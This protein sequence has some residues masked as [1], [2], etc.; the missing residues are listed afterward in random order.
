[1]NEL[2]F[3]VKMTKEENF[4]LHNGINKESERNKRK[5]GPGPAG[6][7]PRLRLAVPFVFFR[8][9]IVGLSKILD[10][11]LCGRKPVKGPHGEVDGAAVVDSKLF[12]DV[13]QRVKV[14]AGVK[15]FLVLPVA[16]FRLA[17]VAGCVRPYAF[18]L[19]TEFGKGFLKERRTVRF[20]IVQPVG[21]LN[22]CRSGYTQ[23]HRGIFQQ[24]GEGRGWKNRCCVPQRLRDSGSGNTHQ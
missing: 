1:M 2:E 3:I 23:W 13:I 19:D 10:S 24:H 22:R 21:E 11:E 9:R 15:P 18:V 7:G 17:V 5:R 4:T 20:G 16:A 12:S 6:P 8:T 14:V